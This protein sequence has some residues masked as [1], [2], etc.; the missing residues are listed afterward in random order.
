MADGIDIKIDDNEVLALLKRLHAKVSDMTPAMQ[1]VG[2]LVKVSVKNNFFVG[3]RYSEAGSWRGGGK[4]WQPLSISTL[5]AGKK[6]K[7]VGK[8]GRFIKGKNGVEARFSNRH[9]LIKNGGLMGSIKPL[10]TSSGVTIG[11]N[12]EYAA[13]HQFGGKAGIGK[14]VTIPA[15]PFLAVQDEDMQEIKDVLIKHIGV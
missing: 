9:T 15:R 5:F 7:F 8:R 14:K 13:I 6:K 1:E 3:G 10:A 12:K 11:T 4:T 2:E